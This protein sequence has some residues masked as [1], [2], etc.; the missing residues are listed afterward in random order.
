M[1]D[2]ERAGPERPPQRRG[3]IPPEIFDLVVPPLQVGGMCGK[4]Q[5]HS[6]GEC[7]GY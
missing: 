3:V 6:P 1:A 5:S 2:I 4:L 7:H